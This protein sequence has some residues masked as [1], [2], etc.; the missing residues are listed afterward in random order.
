[1][2]RAMLLIA[3]AYCSQI[4]A[5]LNY[6]VESCLKVLG[7]F[8]HSVLVPPSAFDGLTMSREC[9]PLYLASVATYLNEFSLHPSARRHPAEAIN[10]PLRY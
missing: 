6:C 7:A 8:V 1:M 9:L 2:H 4:F 5:T 10:T 3:R